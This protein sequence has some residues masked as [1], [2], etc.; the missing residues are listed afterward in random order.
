MLLALCAGLLAVP[1]RSPADEPGDV[2]RA[3]EERFANWQAR[4]GK[5]V[6]LSHVGPYL[7]NEEFAALVALG[8]RIA[9][10]L[11]EK[12]EAA[13]GDVLVEAAVLAVCRLEDLAPHSTLEEWWRRGGPDEVYLAGVYAKWKAAK[14][15]QEVRLWAEEVSYSDGSKKISRTRTW[16]TPGRAWE[17]LR[18]VG[19]PVIPFANERFR[20][21]DYDLYEILRELTDNKAPESWVTG[22]PDPKWRQ[23]YLAWW[24]HHKD[25]WVIP[26]PKRK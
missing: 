15:G 20:E 21:D 24:E 25:E 22:P 8:P 5:V 12:Y 9:P 7:Q 4:S 14:T 2:R 13:R 17:A 26:F 11:M 1:A 6:Q 18:R 19:L 3:F 16:T 10:M 23:K